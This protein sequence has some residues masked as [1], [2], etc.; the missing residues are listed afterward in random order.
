MGEQCRLFSQS[1]CRAWKVSTG[2]RYARDH[3]RNGDDGH[4]GGGHHDG[5]DERNSESDDGSAFAFSLRFDRLGKSEGV[6]AG[7]AE[8]RLNALHGILIP[9]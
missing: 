5:D 6:A 7:L 8:V 2:S 3:E 4:H 1:L 9:R